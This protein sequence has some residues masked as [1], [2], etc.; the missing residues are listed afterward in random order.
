MQIKQSISLKCHIDFI[1]Y[2]STESPSRMCCSSFSQNIF[3]VL[4]FLGDSW[5]QVL[6]QGSLL[7]A[8]HQAPQGKPLCPGTA[9]D[10][11]LSSH[12]P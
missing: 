12:H 6:S 4:D 9:Q 2:I 5:S 1:L 7:W 11:L 10:C 3:T 8:S